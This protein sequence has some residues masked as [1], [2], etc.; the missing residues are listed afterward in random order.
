M[1]NEETYLTELLETSNEKAYHKV[2]HSANQMYKICHN[3]LLF[4]HLASQEQIIC[5]YEL[6][7]KCI[8]TIFCNIVRNCLQLFFAQHTLN[9]LLSLLCCEE[10]YGF[11]FVSPL[12]WAII[13]CQ[14]LSFCHHHNSKRWVHYSFLHMDVKYL[15]DWVNCPESCG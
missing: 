4:S 14:T 13:S 9:L 7:W 6:V 5:T 1:Q 2:F 3:F 11:F 10:Y 15:N 8:N 12:L